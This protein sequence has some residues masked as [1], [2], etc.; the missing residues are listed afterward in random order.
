M[1]VTVIGSSS[2][3]RRAVEDVVRARELSVLLPER[4][5]MLSSIAMILFGDRNGRHWSQ[6]AVHSE[7]IRV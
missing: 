6:L 5:R 2:L 1:G 3:H 7:G 4:R